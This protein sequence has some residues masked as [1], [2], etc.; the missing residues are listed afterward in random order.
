MEDLSS[1][2][3]RRPFTGSCHCGATRYLVYLT[4]PFVQRPYNPSNREQ[5]VYRC[6]CTICH[7]AGILHVRVRFAP[8][9]FLLLSPLDPFEDLGDYRPG[10]DLRF[11]Y[12][13]TCA[14]R[15]FTFMG[16]GEL[17][18]LKGLDVPSAG[19]DNGPVKAWRPKKEGWR[20]GR[21]EGC[22]LSV[23]GYTIDQGQKDLDLRELTEKKIM[24]YI[25][26]LVDVDKQSPT[27]ERPHFGGAY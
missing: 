13:K 5:T 25:D 2:P 12:C 8:E 11:L 7:K 16:E 19:N 3:V 21:A 10:P 20:E 27:L 6:N 22:Y 26:C 9:D 24:S 14:V 15:C 4:V 23:N 17:V 18:D 1:S